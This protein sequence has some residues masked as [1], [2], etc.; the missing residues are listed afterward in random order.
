MIKQKERKVIVQWLH[1]RETSPSLQKLMAVLL[2]PQI[3]KGD[4]NV[5]NE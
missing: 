5:N 4:N 3:K 1:T 2:K